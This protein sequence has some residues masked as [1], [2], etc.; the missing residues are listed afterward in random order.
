MSSKRPRVAAKLTLTGLVSWAPLV[1]I[2]TG[3]Q[4]GSTF[5]VTPLE[6]TFHRDVV[7]V[8]QQRCQSCHRPGDIAPMPLLTYE[9]TRPWAKAIRSVVLRREMPPWRAD[10]RFGTFSNDRSLTESEIQTLVRWV[11]TGAAEGSPADAPPPLR[12]SDAW[13]IGTPD[14][15]YQMPKE[16]SVPATGT[17]P[18]QWIMIPSGFTEDRWVEAVEVRPGNRAVVHHGVVYARE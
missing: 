6:V 10:P 17:V 5:A 13:R 14:V 15:V 16:F 7:P 1:A 12:S 3:A 8:L 9:Q 2:V 4:L 18:Y 11:D